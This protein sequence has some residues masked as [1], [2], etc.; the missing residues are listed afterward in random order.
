MEQITGSKTPLGNASMAANY[1]P[2]RMFEV[3]FAKGDQEA[4]AVEHCGTNCLIYRMTITEMAHPSGGQPTPVV[5]YTL[6]HVAIRNIGYT[7][8]NGSTGNLCLSAIF[9]YV[10][11]NIAY[12]P[13]PAH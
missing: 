4:K 8:C 5:V 3:H 1:G 13:R 7:P 12:P 9:N 6:T 2:T 10:N 11:I